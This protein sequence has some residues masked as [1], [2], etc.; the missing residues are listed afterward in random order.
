MPRCLNCR[1]KF[2]PKYFLDKHCNSPNCAEAKKEYQSGKMAKTP[3]VKKPIPWPLSQE[4]NATVLEVLFI[5]PN[6]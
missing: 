4:L 2:E 6:I 5:K 1:E 3:I